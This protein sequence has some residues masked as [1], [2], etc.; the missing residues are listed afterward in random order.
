MALRAAKAYR[1]ILVPVSESGTCDQA[2]AVACRLAA[3]RGASV[4][5][6]CA[7]EVPAELPLDAQLD[8]EEDAAR[9]VLVEARSIAEL[10]GVSTETRLVRARSAGE[11]IVQGAA[12][13]SAEIVILGARRHT[14]AS[15]RTPVF[16]RTVAFVLMHATCRVMVE[17]LPAR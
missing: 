12:E 17:A 16:G 14:R 9:A 8:D 7:V 4:T 1:R 6:L 11:A 2:M 13:R 5:I 3:G 10:H 15:R